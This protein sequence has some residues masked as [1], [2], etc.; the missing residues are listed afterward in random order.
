MLANA[1]CVKSSCIRAL[2]V[3][4]GHREGVFFMPMSLCRRHSGTGR[5]VAVPHQYSLIVFV[6][7]ILI[8]FI[9]AL[10]WIGSLAAEL[11]R[12]TLF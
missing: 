8:A 7:P 1:G 6:K 3:S 11:R 5:G 12:C 4:Q 9:S 2:P 10:L